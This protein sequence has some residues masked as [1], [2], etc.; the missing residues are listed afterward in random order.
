MR[1]C[2]Y[3][4]TALPMVGGQEYVVDALAREYLAY[5]HDVVVLAPTPRSSAAAGE[6]PPYEVVR[7][8]RFISTRRLVGWYSRYL[9]A[10]HR[11]QPYDL[12]HCHSTYPTGYLAALAG[13]RT[14]VPFVVTSHGGDVNPN[15]PKLLL[16]EIRNRHRQAMA[17]AAALVSISGFTRDGYARL[18]PDAGH[19]HD[20]PNGVHL[21]KFEQPAARPT[22][23]DIAVESGRYLLFL[24]R[25]SSRKGV[26][27]LL[28]AYAL[29]AADDRIPLVLA[30]DGEEREAL[31]RQAARLG[32]SQWVHFAGRVAGERKTYLL[33][34]AYAVV[35]PSRDWEAFPLVVLEACACALPLIA[36]RIPGLGELVADGRNGW[37]VEPEAP[38]ALA[39]AL[40]AALADPTRTAALG[41]N[42]HAMAR[43]YDWPTIAGRY[44]E[45]FEAVLAANGT[46]RAG[47]PQS[48]IHSESLPIE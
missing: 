29:L 9:V 3:T 17:R 36:T 45:L 19:V 33:Q 47:A 10:L 32:L 7:H 38:D 11:R 15:N 12:V 41:R 37:L 28:D 13:R 20:I 23:I 6:K 46:V 21:R 35:M 31:E 5:G 14:G 8:P 30:G 22:G 44:I 48:S 27:L 26:D 42:A 2:I 43:S 25:L 18:M 39:G 4:E 16:P 24:G 40:R 1:I 34:N